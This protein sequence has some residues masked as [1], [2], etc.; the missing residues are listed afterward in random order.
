M[1]QQGAA[2][3]IISE[4]LEG[5][6]DPVNDLYLLIGE[7]MIKLKRIYEPPDHADGYRV[8]VER[9]WP[10]GM[11]KSRAQVDLWLKE[12]APSP[13]LRA[14]YSHDPTKWDEFQGL[15]QIELQQNPALELIRLVLAGPPDSH[16]CFC[17]SRFGTQQRL[18]AEKFP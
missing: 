14:W 12:I 11:S 9:L 1:L 3:S 2:R 6:R 8:L 16:I 5:N 7:A 18:G 13:E 10:R 4:T 17:C 15:Y